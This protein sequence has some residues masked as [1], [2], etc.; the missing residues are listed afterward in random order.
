MLS[1]FKF[2]R[3]AQFC[4]SLYARDEAARRELDD[5]GVNAIYAP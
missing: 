4:D 2:G 5:Q 3:G 1:G